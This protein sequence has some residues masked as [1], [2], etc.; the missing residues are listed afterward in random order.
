[1]SD[2]PDITRSSSSTDSRIVRG[3]GL[4][5]GSVATA[6]TAG[7]GGLRARAQRVDQ[8]VSSPAGILAG[9]DRGNHLA[10]AVDD[11]RARR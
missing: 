2:T 8:R 3:V 1:M 4:A 7:D 6:A 11:R 10:D 9:V 5:L